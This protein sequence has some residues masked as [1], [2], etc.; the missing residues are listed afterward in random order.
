MRN[1]N[2]HAEVVLGGVDAMARAAAS[3][4]SCS[5]DESEI[6]AVHWTVLLLKFVPPAVWDPKGG[7]RNTAMPSNG[8]VDGAETSARGEALDLEDLKEV[9][10][11]SYEPLRIQDPSRCGH[12]QVWTSSGV[13]MSIWP[14]EGSLLDK[15]S[16]LGNGVSQ[17]PFR[18][19]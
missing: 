3:K 13:D 10:Q 17:C 14:R 8:G 7:S 11:E 19:E 4:V 6:L 9:H 1:I 12:N 15:L 18:R 2:R 16:V 5:P